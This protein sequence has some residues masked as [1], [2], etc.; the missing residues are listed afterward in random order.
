MEDTG[1]RLTECERLLL[2]IQKAHDAW[3][4]ALDQFNNAVEKDI[5]DDAIYLLM[6][7]EMRYEGLMRV[8][9]RN[10]LAVDLRGRIAGAD[11]SDPQLSEN[12]FVRPLLAL[13]AASRLRR[14][15][16]GKGPAAASER[17]ADAAPPPDLYS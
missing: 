8:A 12:V 4:M 13:R 5:V 15:A 11:D 7:A 6:A 3:R 16:A 14:R 17:H 9:R 10:Q 2:D 1:Q